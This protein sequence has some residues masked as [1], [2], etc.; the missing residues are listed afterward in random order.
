MTIQTLPKWTFRMMTSSSIKLHYFKEAFFSIGFVHSF[1]QL[2]CTEWWGVL[3]FSQDLLGEG[4]RNRIFLS[5]PFQSKCIREF[6]YEVISHK[7]PKHKSRD[8]NLKVWALL[9]RVSAH[10]LNVIYLLK[11]SSDCVQF[12]YAHE[13]RPLLHV[14][15]IVIVMTSSQVTWPC[16]KDAFFIFSYLRKHTYNWVQILQ[17]V[18]E[19]HFCDDNLGNMMMTSSGVKL[20]CF[21]DAFSPLVVCAFCPGWRCILSS[22]VERLWLCFLFLIFKAVF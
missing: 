5:S 15:C 16:I 4:K 6:K 19:K 3:I 21:K 18:R 13:W 2:Y 10:N 8:M 9:H 1:C 14:S 20:H 22:E 7:N 17:V 11:R 12:W